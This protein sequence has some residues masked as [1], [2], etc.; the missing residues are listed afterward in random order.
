MFG[1][2]RLHFPA[3]EVGQPSEFAA[4]MF[5]G[6]ETVEA[7]V[8]FNKFVGEIEGCGRGSQWPRRCA[9]NQ[10]RKVNY[11]LDRFLWGRTSKRISVCQTVKERFF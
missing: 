6:I 7:V 9:Q 10:D 8:R 2:I 11:T 5:G 4:A 1:I 3:R